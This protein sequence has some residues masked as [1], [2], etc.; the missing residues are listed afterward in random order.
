MYLSNVAH[1]IVSQGHFRRV[2]GDFVIGRILIRFT[3][4]KFLL[5]TVKESLKSVLN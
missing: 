3:R 1:S 4:H 2:G 5:V